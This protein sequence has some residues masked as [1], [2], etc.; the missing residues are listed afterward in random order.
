[1]RTPVV[2]WTCLALGLICAEVLLPDVFLLWLGV[3]AG[4]VLVLVLLFPGVGPLWQAVAFV[5]ASFLLVPVY[6]HLF[7][8]GEGKSDQPLLN[9]KAAQMI[10]QSVLLEHAII[11]GRGKIKIGDALWT[12]TGPDLPAGTRVRIV[13][14]DAMTLTVEPEKGV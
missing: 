13:A 8:K 10:G 6:R 4:V 7:K 9:K 2:V 11:A 1:M 5:F 14:A 12:A 3:A